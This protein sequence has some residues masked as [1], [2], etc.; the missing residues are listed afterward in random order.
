M[1]TNILAL[2]FTA[3]IFITACKKE[4]KEKDYSLELKIDGTAWV[5]EKNQSGVYSTN[6]KILTFGG[7][8]END[9]VFLASFTNV[10]NTGNYYIPSSGTINLT[11]HDGVGGLKIY[12]SNKPD[13]HFELDFY[14]RIEEGSVFG[15]EYV[16]LNFTGV[17]YNFSGAPDS[18]VITD[19]KLRY[20]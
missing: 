20:N 16:E 15:L 4:E 8:K 10:T 13:A 11:L 12:T 9:D 2:A 3:L 19:G 18:V 5:A 6:D 14:N 1:K 7:E 17:L